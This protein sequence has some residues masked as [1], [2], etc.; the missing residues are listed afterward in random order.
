MK[1]AALY[2]VLATT[3]LTQAHARF[4]DRPG[5]YCSL[6]RAFGT[7]TI[8]GGLLYTIYYL[9][10]NAPELN[11]HP[12]DI[13]NQASIREALELVEEEWSI[14]INSMREVNTLIDKA[15][16]ERTLDKPEQAAQRYWTAAAMTREIADVY[17]ESTKKLFYLTY[18]D[19]EIFGDVARLRDFILQ[20][21]TLSCDTYNIASKLFK[22]SGD[23]SS[24]QRV[25]EAK[26]CIHRIRGLHDEGTLS[27]LDLQA[28]FAIELQQSLIH[29]KGI[30][31]DQPRGL[32]LNTGVVNNIEKFNVETQATRH[33]AAI[34]VFD[35]L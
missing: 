30:P 22:A 34:R 24:A 12:Q 10:G 11:N 9:Y 23:F 32:E 18:K 13:P 29:V 14:A 6:P 1:K 5:S 27:A 8:G 35:E 16:N 2:L 4:N 28:A 15:A 21:C 26:E 25:L 20:T 7:V 31:Q 33:E 17:R 3:L 19:G